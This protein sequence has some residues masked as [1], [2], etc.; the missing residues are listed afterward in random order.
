MKLS[1]G[2]RIILFIH[3]LLSVLLLVGVAASGWIAS[4]FESTALART[5][6]IAFAAV[7]ALACAAAAWVVFWRDPRRA[8]RG[9]ITVD[10]SETGRVRIAVGAVEQMVK[11]AVRAVEG[12]SEM[13]IAIS[14]E[15]DA[16]AINVSVA[17]L[18]G[19]H[20]PTVTMNMQRAIRQYVEANCGVAVQS[21]SVS[22]QSVVS[23]AEATGRKARRASARPEAAVPAPETEAPAPEVVMAE[24]VAVEPPAQDAAFVPEA[25]AEETAAQEWTPEDAALAS[26][27]A[28]YVP[29]E[30][31]DSGEPSGLAYEAPEPEARGA[32]GE[33]Q[34]GV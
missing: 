21:V 6:F 20:V 29:A 1:L 34:N 23:P 10:S 3:W 4:W 2:K 5:L 17:L 8:E 14:G 25:V 28:D 24:A 12:I 16:I 15:D 7:Y 22:I 27:A 30:P 18:S 31:T 19:A 33:G 13:K 32:E 9:F 11:Q 26:E